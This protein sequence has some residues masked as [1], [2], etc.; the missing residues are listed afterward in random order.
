MKLRAVL[1]SIYRDY[2]VGDTYLFLGE[3]A[4]KLLLPAIR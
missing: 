2:P 1:L 3:F 4:K